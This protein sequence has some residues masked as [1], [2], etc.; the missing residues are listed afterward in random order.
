V[1]LVAQWYALVDDAARR[2]VCPSRSTNEACMIIVSITATALTALL[3]FP[4]VAPTSTTGPMATATAVVG[5]PRPSL[6]RLPHPSLRLPRF[7]RP[8]T[9]GGGLDRVDMRLKAMVR[10]QEAWYSDHGRYSKDVN[11]VQSAVTR[12]DA[13]FERVEL[14]IL[15]ADR[16][17]WTA[18]ASHPDALGK[19]CVVYVGYRTLVP[20]TRASAVEAVT[21]GMPACDP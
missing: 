3:G 4:P 19:S 12:A 11:A 9:S 16:R 2:R 21:A 20:R 1:R 5:L 6:P 13:S 18:M 17:G 15:F 14:Q 7:R 8:A 10:D